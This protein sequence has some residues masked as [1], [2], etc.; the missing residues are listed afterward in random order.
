VTGGFSN[1]EDDTTPPPGVACWVTGSGGGGANSNDVDGG[2]TYLTSPPFGAP[3]ILDMALRY[4]RWYYDD[5]SSSDSFKAE[6][7]NNGGSA[8]TTLE[9]RVSPTGGWATFTTD[10]ATVLAPS[11]DMRLRFTATD[12]GTDSVV[13]AAVDE[14]HISGTWVDCQGYTPPSELP[15]NGVGNTL[16]VS[17]GPGGHAVLAWTAPPVDSGHGAA[18][19]YRIV[20]SSA[21]Q[22]PRGEFGSATSTRWVDVDALHTPDPYFYL[23]TAEN[24]GGSE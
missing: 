20:R 19:L 22:G 8:W 23:V 9:Q 10:L 15:P 13:E 21:P 3:F 4:D 5:S 2:S 6:V 14:V 17:R 12:G 24:S 7:S 16:R 1:P 11:E 18:T